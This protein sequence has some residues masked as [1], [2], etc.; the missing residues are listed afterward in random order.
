M[1]RAAARPA[2]PI[3]ESSG[4][5]RSNREQRRQWRKQTWL[6]R[7]VSTYGWRAYALPVLVVLTGVV[8]YQTVTGTAAPAPEQP[9]AVRG[10]RRSDRAGRRSSGRR[11]GADRLRREPADRGPAGGR[12]VHRGRREKTWHIVP[13]TTRR[14][15]RAPRRR[16]PTP[17]RWR[18]ASTPLRSAA[19]R[20]SPGWSPRRWATRRVGPTT[21][22]RLPADRRQQPGD[23]TR[24][25]G[26]VVVPDDGSGGAATRSRWSRRASTRS[27]VPTPSP[28]CSSTRPAGCA[29]RC[30]SRVTSAPTAST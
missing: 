27:T 26:V 19:T 23:Q 8:L 28:G 30:R 12:R 13:G 7:F 16:S 25:P 14:S 24:F 3:T 11:R 4:R 6:G 22:V 17:S 15:A 10:R 5:P 2:R 9:D 18:T 20:V 21:P 1:A 29:G